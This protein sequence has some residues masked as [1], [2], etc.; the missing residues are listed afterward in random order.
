MMNATKRTL[1]LLLVCATLLIGAAALTA[2]SDA[3]AQYNA[4]AL[5]E[6]AA[7]LPLTFGPPAQ[8]AI[9][10]LKFAPHVLALPTGNAVV[11]TNYDP[12][13]HTL[14]A[15]D[16]AFQS[17]PLNPGATFTWRAPADGI[18]RYTTVD[19]PA[20][21]GVIVASPNGAADWF[22]GSPVAAAYLSTCAGC[23]GIDRQG[24]IGPALT[25]DVLVQNDDFYFDVI[26]N[27]RPG[28][29]MPAWGLLGLTDQEIWLMLGYLRSE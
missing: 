22:S 2:H 28:T 13:A 1:L 8:I 24:G 15:L 11:W 6:H 19:I 16:A 26:K 14:A 20:M 27:G 29:I 21:E 23:H 9:A 4:P 3:N 12:H 25:P 7:F 18:Y 10:G 5:Q 17:P